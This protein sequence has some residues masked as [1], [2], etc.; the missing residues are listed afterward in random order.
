MNIILIGFMGSGK[1]TIGKVLSE[2]MERPFLDTDEVISK[3]V[4]L[5]ISEIFK[6][7]GEKFFRE[8]ERKLI[9]EMLHNIE[10]SIISTGG[11]MPCYL[12]NGKLLRE[13]GIVAYLKAPFDLI[14]K[15]INSENR[16]LFSEEESLRYLY[17]TRHECYTHVCHFTVEGSAEPLVVVN[18][19]EACIT[20]WVVNR[21]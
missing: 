9:F 11:G 17:L 12:D 15:R 20:R 7:Y 6:K 21:S 16:P 19:L 1:S 8:E 5:S 4:G 13:I 3:N 14:L 18:S 2:K 10:D